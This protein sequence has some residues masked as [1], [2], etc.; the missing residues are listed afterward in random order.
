VL[1]AEKPRDP[2][3]FRGRLDGSGNRFG[4][5]VD[6]RLSELRFVELLEGLCSR[7]SAYAL[8]R[9]SAAYLEREPD[10]PKAEWVRVSGDGAV[11]AATEDD[12]GLRGGQGKAKA[13]SKE[14]EGF[15]AALVEVVEEPLAVALRQEDFNSTQTEKLLCRQLSTHCRGVKRHKKATLNTAEPVVVAAESAA[16]AA[17]P[18]GAAE[19]APSDDVRHG[20]SADAISHEEL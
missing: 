8:W 13:H 19:A 14:I 12:P 9:P 18:A 3:D 2:L 4:K 10:T 11:S 6:Y 15:C 5:V 20:E 16:A 7:L 1:E 17:E